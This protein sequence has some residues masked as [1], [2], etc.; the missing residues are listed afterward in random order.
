MVAADVMFET[1]PDMSE[2]N[3]FEVADRIKVLVAQGQ[4]QSQGNLDNMRYSEIRLPD[5]A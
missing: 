2:V 5:S 4:L 1:D 3:D